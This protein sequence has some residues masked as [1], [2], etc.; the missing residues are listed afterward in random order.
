MF[1]VLTT[2]YS[3]P[4]DT[5]IYEHSI[6]RMVMQSQILYSWNLLTTIGRGW[7]PPE[8]YSSSRESWFARARCCW[9]CTP[10][11]GY[12]SCVSD[13]QSQ[14]AVSPWKDQK[15]TRSIRTHILI[16]KKSFPG[17]LAKRGTSYCLLSF[18][19]HAPAS[20]QAAQRTEIGALSIRRI[21]SFS[22]RQW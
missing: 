21:S 19:Q 15:T 18:G 17:Q 4:G 11:R 14:Q 3:R 1:L 20:R 10:H 2:W 6:C 5:I 22:R 9:H 16:P 7:H 8:R 12:E 13:L